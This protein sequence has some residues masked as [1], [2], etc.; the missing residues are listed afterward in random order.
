MSIRRQSIHIEHAD[1]L[2]NAAV[3]LATIVAV[4]L[5]APSALRLI[6]ALP[7]VFLAPG[8]ALLAT[9]FAPSTLQGVERLVM[10]VGSSIGIT[11]LVGLLL[12]WSPLA[13]G[14][15]SWAVVLAAITLVGLGLAY[16]RR[17]RSHAARP[18]RAARGIRLRD[19]VPILVAS[20]AAIAILVGTREIAADQE[21]PPPTQLWMLPTA[22]DSPDA[23][24]GVRAGSPG[25]YTV[26]V[27]S[28][29]V[30]LQEFPI[31]LAA[32]GAWETILP[33]TTEE[34]ERPIVARL[35]EDGGDQE[36]RFVVLQPPRDAS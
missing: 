25:N 5:Q 2:L 27:T 14:P 23:R 35:Y 6:V 11:M 28:T 8:Y 22:A 26:R 33:F 24:L 34:R 19:A 1:L 18:D 16:I 7:L 30:L 9:L 15:L 10:A 3:A 29:G 4:A 31:A 21:P 20:L 13:L 32:G 36:L 17:R 12:A